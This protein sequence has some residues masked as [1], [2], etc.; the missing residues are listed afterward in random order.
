MRDLSTDDC[1]TISANALLML[2]GITSSN[3]AVNGEIINS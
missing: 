1:D 2:G 3:M